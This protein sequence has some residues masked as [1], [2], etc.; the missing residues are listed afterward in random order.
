MLT[1]ESL[2]INFCGNG[3]IL[4]HKTLKSPEISRVES[5]N[6]FSLFPKFYYAIKQNLVTER[7][8]TEF[9]FAPLVKLRITLKS[10]FLCIFPMKHSLIL[11]RE[12][13]SG[14]F[15]AQ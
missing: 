9:S 14:I 2:Q 1:L 8:V 3:G 10:E 7:L 12:S 11:F 4:Y 6:Q 13:H 15:T 5:A